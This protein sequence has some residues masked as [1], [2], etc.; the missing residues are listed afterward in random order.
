MADYTRHSVK[1]GASL[2]QWDWSSEEIYRVCIQCNF[3]NGEVSGAAS[4]LWR[5]EVKVESNNGKWPSEYVSGIKDRE[6]SIQKRERGKE[7][8]KN[9]ENK[10]GRGSSLFSHQIIDFKS[11]P[12]TEKFVASRTVFYLSTQLY[13]CIR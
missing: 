10:E 8:W 12:T 7:S 5:A 9:M 6:E 3:A 4:N 13:V 11:A 1:L 2:W